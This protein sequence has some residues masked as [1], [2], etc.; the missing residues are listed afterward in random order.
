MIGGIVVGDKVKVGS[1]HVHLTH[2][3]LEELSVFGGSSI[4][5]EVFP[6]GE[7]LP[8]SEVLGKTEARLTKFKHDNKGLV[9]EK[10]P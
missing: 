3:S 8:R 4:I 7:W 6:N 5:L 2:W 9:V 10:E 1:T